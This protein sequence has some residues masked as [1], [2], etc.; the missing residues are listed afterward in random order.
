[1]NSDNSSKYTRPDDA[2]LRMR[3]TE[4]QFAVTQLCTTEPPYFNAY[5]D[6][7][8]EGIYADIV[9]GE[10]LFLSRD[11]F[12]SGG[13]PAFYKPI[14]RESIVNDVLKWKKERWMEKY[15][16]KFTAESAAPI[17]AMFTLTD[18]LNMVDFDIPSI[19]IPLFL[20]PKNAWSKKDITIAFL[21]SSFKK[22]H[23][24]FPKGKFLLT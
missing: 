2:I 9:T 14:N 4:D 16:Q 18:R 6:E 3:L 23:P 19:V 1:M 12:H 10:P 7:E 8:R 15:K 13:W 11:K 21:T 24:Y 5:W 20:F 22:P 17:W